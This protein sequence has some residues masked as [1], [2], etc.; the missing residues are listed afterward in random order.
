MSDNSYNKDEILSKIN[1]GGLE[2]S[3]VSLVCCI[4]ILLLIFFN[5][6]LRSLTYN[7]LICIFISEIIGNIGHIYEYIVNVDENE[8]KNYNGWYRKG[9]FFLIPFSDLSTML[10]FCFFSYCSIEVIKKRNSNIKTKEKMFFLIS[11][12]TAGI[13]SIIFL[14]LASYL[15]SLK[16][17]DGD[18]ISFYFFKKNFLRFIHI[19]IIIVMTLYISYNTFVVTQFMKEKQQTDRVNA[20][21]LAKLIKV[22]FRFPLICFLYWIFY[23]LSLIS[24]DI[25]NNFN[26]KITFIFR[27]FSVSFFNLRGLLIFLNTIKTNKVE[28]LI[29]RIIEINIKHNLL[30]KFDLFS[31]K[32]KK[33]IKENDKKKELEEEKE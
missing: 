16:F 27:L 23:L 15:D 1:N 8:Q 13:Y 30:L 33:V 26:Y 28:V 25:D 21:K 18:D 32:I 10:L 9:H 6:I 12:L 22:L 29:Q 20:W 14:I 3:I 4:A 19:S 24:E 11:F 7:F 2:F 5:K 17:G 31:T